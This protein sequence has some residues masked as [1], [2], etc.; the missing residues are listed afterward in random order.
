MGAQRGIGRFS[1]IFLQRPGGVDYRGIEGQ[2]FEQR[3][4]GIEYRDGGVGRFS[5]DWGGAVGLRRFAFHV[6]FSISLEGH[7]FCRNEQSGW[8]V[9]FELFAPPS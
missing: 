2:V 9:Q 4:G 7:Y 6:A 3:L 1:S 5:C 8:D